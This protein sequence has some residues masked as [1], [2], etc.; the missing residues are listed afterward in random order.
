MSAWIESHQTLRSHPKTRRLARRCGGIAKAVGHLHCLWW[1]CLDYAQDGDL[2]DFDAE[3]I[4]IA[5]EWDGEPAE[6][7]TMLTD[8]GFIDN[9]KGMHVH[10]WYDYA[11]KLID[12]RERNAER[13]RQARAD[14]VQR[15]CGAREHT[16]SATEPNR[17]EQ[18]HTEDL[19]AEPPVD[20]VLKPRKSSRE[21]PPEYDLV[22]VVGPI[23]RLCGVKNIDTALDESTDLNRAIRRYLAAVDVL[24]DEYLGELTGKAL[25]EALAKCRYASLERITTKPK[26]PAAYLTAAAGNATC[27]GDLVGDELV[28]ELRRPKRRRKSEPQ[29]IGEVQ[30]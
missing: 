6:F 24:V 21:D 11:G 17:T 22:S 8:C 5:A 19:C 28:D 27:L 25:D 16:C 9:S 2:T 26:N 18:N 23:G 15:T 10:D 13:M 14:S 12:R 20:K 1:W 29:R 3:D 30:P 7:V 4:A